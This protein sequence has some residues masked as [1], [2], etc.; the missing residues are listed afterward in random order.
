[1][2]TFTSFALSFLKKN[3]KDVSDYAQLITCLIEMVIVY[4]LAGSGARFWEAISA[5]KA[6]SQIQ[7]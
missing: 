4:F 5:V 3:D 1:M 6:T 2:L 7:K